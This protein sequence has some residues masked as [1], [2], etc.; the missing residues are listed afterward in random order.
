MQRSLDK[1]RIEWRSIPQDK[2]RFSGGFL[3]EIGVTLLGSVKR[4]LHERRVAPW[5]SPEWKHNLAALVSVFNLGK[6]SNFLFYEPIVWAHFTEPQITGGFAH[7]LQNESPEHNDIRV[8][9]FL[10]ALDVTPIDEISTPKVEAEHRTS[11]DQRIDLLVTWDDEN[12]GKNAAVI[13]AK[14]N[15]LVTRGQLNAYRR[16][17]RR[18]LRANPDACN[19]FVVAPHENINIDRELRHNKKWRFVSWHTLLL[20]FD[21]VLPVEADSEAFRQFRRTVWNQS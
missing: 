21:G 8:R 15:H 16:Y 7:F 19:F 4:F 5:P 20:R 13:E 17:V 1:T 3:E 2:L 9:A 6:Q 10:Q 14:F 18:S 12:N 11:G